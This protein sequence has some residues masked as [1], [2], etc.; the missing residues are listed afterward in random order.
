MFNATLNF[1]VLNIGS[2]LWKNDVQTKN[3]FAVDIC[4]FSLAARVRLSWSGNNRIIE[5][6]NSLEGRQDVAICFIG[7]LILCF[8]VCL[9]VSLCVSYFALVSLF[10]LLYLLK[11]LCVLVTLLGCL[12][13]FF[14]ICLY[15]CLCLFLLCFDVYA[16]CWNRCRAWWAPCMAANKVKFDSCNNSWSSVHA[17]IIIIVI[18]LRPHQIIIII[19]IVIITIIVMT[20]LTT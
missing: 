8:F 20:P 14:S 15:V 13:L 19:F 3:F 16:T 5:W 9:D 2:A 12:S 17:V 10:V 18:I 4:K 7:C 1:S 6:E 11:C